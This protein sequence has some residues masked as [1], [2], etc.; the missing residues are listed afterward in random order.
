MLLTSGMAVSHGRPC[1]VEPVEWVCAR[2]DAAAGSTRDSQ[3]GGAVPVGLASHSSADGSQSGESTGP[4]LSVRHLSIAF[5]GVNALSDVNLD[6]WPGECVGLIGPNGAGK[7]TLLNCISRLLE[8]SIGSILIEGAEC[9]RV[10]TARIVSLGVKR[11]FQNIATFQ[12][13]RVAEV[14][15]VGAHHETRSSFLDAVLGTTLA[16]RESRRVQAMVEESAAALGI[17]ELLDHVVRDLPYGNQKKVDIGR[18]LM[19]GAKIL[20]LDEP[21]AGLSQWEWLEMLETLRRLKSETT[22]G[23]LVIEHQL[24]F[25]RRLADRIYALDAGQVIAQGTPDVVLSNRAVVEA[26]IGTAAT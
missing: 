21:A 12:E 2:A 18:A 7:T 15:A 17:S 1:D 20:L 24:E 14:L 9:S 11:T 26:Y 13:M 8:P 23:I 22:T 5:G 4:L 25:V 19:G 6:L 16:S 3:P 10:P